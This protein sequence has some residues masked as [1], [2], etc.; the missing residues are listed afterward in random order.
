MKYK[1]YMIQDLS[2]D[3]L[4]L[5]SSIYLCGIAAHFVCSTFQNTDV[6]D[7]RI[8]LTADI[9]AG[10]SVKLSNGHR[11]DCSLRS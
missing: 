1:E 8:T 6:V 4:F 9:K 3:K 7:L 11:T 10:R 5:I 2:H